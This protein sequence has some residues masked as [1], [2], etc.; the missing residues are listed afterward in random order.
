MLVTILGRQALHVASFTS[1]EQ[2]REA[3]D[4]FVAGYNQ[5]AA[6]FEWKKGVVNPSA[7]KHNY[8]Y[9][10]IYAT[11]GSFFQR[12]AVEFTVFSPSSDP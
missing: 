5:K 6:P 10:R 11:K 12:L 3:I 1:P 2:M 8:A 4:R 7:P 9:L